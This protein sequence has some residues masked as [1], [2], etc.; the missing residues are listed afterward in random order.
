MEPQPTTR[1]KNDNKNL[2][3]W[4]QSSHQAIPILYRSLRRR[5]R[6]YKRIGHPHYG[7]HF[8]HFS[9]HPSLLK[10]ICGSD[11]STILNKFCKFVLP[12]TPNMNRHMSIFQS[13]V[14]QYILILK[15]MN[16]TDLIVFWLCDVTTNLRRSN[17]I[18][19]TWFLLQQNILLFIIT[20]KHACDGI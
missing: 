18:V 6:E 11:L 13:F 7:F 2:I 5:L 4:A 19:T 8:C 1:E 3:Q 9:T 20:L 15:I 16:I 12:N 10:M 14:P 17:N